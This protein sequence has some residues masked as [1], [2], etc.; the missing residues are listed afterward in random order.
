MVR[1]EILDRSL[2]ERHF[3][4]LAGQP[5]D[6]RE[7]LAIRRPDP[8]L[9]ANAPQERL[10]DQFVR[11]E[12][13]REDDQQLERHRELFPGDQR[14]IIDPL[15]QRHDPAIEQILRADDLPTEVVD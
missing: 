14:E 9:V 7:H 2:V 11:V 3:L 8:N 6:P 10:V 1:E 4:L 12:V 13:G 5:K 15:F